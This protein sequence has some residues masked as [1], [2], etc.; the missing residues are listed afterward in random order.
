MTEICPKSDAKFTDGLAGL[1]NK[2]VSEDG[3]GLFDCL[4]GVIS[5]EK[6]KLESEITQNNILDKRRRSSRLE[7]LDD[8]DPTRSKYTVDK[9]R[10][11][12]FRD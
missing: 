5:E 12:E 1:S 10:H 2:K 4:F 9:L 7:K 8:N 11:N 3:I 6:I